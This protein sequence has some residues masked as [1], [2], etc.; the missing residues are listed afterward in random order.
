MKK[1]EE[2][3]VETTTFTVGDVVTTS[4]GETGATANCTGIVDPFA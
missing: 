3:I 4:S 2:P 1:F